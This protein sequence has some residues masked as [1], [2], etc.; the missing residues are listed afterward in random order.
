M[1][2]ALALLSDTSSDSPAVLGDA[3]VIIRILRTRLLP[4]VEAIRGADPTEIQS[5][6]IRLVLE[7]LC[8]KD[9]PE[10]EYLL[11]HLSNWYEDANGWKSSVEQTLK[12]L[13]SIMKLYHC[14]DR[15]S[16]TAFPIDHRRRM[17]GR[18]EVPVISRSHLPRGP[19]ASPSVL[20][21]ASAPRCKHD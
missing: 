4:E 11:M 19:P 7:L 8:V 18:P 2:S 1:K 13:V 15:R 14:H 5:N 20:H 6:V 21:A 12:N 9:C 3:E 16:N 10:Q 17:A